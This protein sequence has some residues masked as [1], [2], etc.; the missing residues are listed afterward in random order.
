[1][2]PNSAHK[3]IN[4]NNLIYSWT[5]EGPLGAQF[6]KI[7][8]VIVVKQRSQYND[9]SLDKLYF[10]LV[11]ICLCTSSILRHDLNMEW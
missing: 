3:W 11:L 9:R 4:L 8:I 6:N 5:I 7:L 1:M 10:L 2:L